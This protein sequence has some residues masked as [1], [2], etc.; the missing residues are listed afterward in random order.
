MSTF[1][2]SVFLFAIAFLI[3]ATTETNRSTQAQSAQSSNQSVGFAV[4]FSN[5]V[6]TIGVTM[7]PTARARLFVPNHFILAGEGESLTPLVV[8]TARCAGV[9]TAGHKPTTAEIVQIG[10]V[11]VPPDFTGDINNYTIWYSTSDAKLAD[12]L[13]KVDINAQ[14]VPTIAYDYQSG[15]NSFSAQLPVPSESRFTLIGNVQPSPNPTGSFTAN[16]WQQTSTGVCKDD[17]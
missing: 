12:R 13:R 8:R 1:K 3:T 17:H 5:C 7:V 4:E 14:H 9:A 16:W 10:A 11:I 15:N 6:E 2:R